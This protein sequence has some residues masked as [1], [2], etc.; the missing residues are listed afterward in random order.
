M[1]KEELK[2][3]VDFF[4]KFVNAALSKETDKYKPLD[5]VKNYNIVRNELAKLLVA[6]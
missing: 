3:A 6:P 1:S 5:V 2:E 4:D